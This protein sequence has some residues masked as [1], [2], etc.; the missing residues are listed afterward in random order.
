MNYHNFSCLRD[1]CGK[2]KKVEDYFSFFKVYNC[3]KYSG[4]LSENSMFKFLKN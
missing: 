1:E 2:L 3:S 4:K